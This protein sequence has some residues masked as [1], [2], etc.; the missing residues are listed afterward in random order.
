MK[1]KY[2]LLIAV[3]LLIIIVSVMLWE[4]PK[5]GGECGRQFSGNGDVGDY[6]QKIMRMRGGDRL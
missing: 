3:S 2:G 5:L 4:T 6:P 1:K